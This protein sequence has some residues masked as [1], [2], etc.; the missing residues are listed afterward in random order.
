[1]ME[2]SQSDCLLFCQK[3]DD[4]TVLQ[5]DSE[6]RPI[7]LLK[8]I[9]KL[10]IDKCLGYC[11][12]G[13]MNGRL[14]EKFRKRP[15]GLESIVEALLEYSRQGINITCADVTG[16]YWVDIGTVE[17]YE[18]LINSPNPFAGKAE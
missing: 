9:D 3:R 6:N 17:S 2:R 8:S 14:L 18:S 5:V 10:P 11:G 15:L 16:E 13:I 7:R 1:M 4:P 12:V